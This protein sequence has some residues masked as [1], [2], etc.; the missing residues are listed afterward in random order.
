MDADDP[1]A[2]FIAWTV[3]GTH[4]QGDENGWRKWR[5]GNQEARP[6]LAQWH[7]E[8]LTYAVLLLVPE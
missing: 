2:F 5:H 1:I 4:L 6:Q 3:Y 8:R 7:R